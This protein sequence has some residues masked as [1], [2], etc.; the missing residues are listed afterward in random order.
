MISEN[1][2]PNPA[3]PADPVKITG[4]KKTRKR[5]GLAPLEKKRD[6]EKRAQSAQQADARSLGANSMAGGE[7][8]FLLL[9]F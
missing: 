3:L 5:R 7:F 1:L 4:R 8:R 2:R 6:T 9:T